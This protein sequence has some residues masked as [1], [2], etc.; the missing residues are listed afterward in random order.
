MIDKDF[1]NFISESLKEDIKDGDH[2]SLSIIH[3][4]S[5]S[6][7]NLLIKDEGI[8]AGIEL[9]IM[10]FKEVDPDLAIKIF[11]KDGE[12]VK[13]GDVAF[14]VK[15]S[16]MSILKSERLVLNCMQHMSS[17]A[18]KTNYLNSLIKN[19][20]TK[21]LDTRK[22]IPLNRKL[23]KW[24]VR[25]GGGNN[26]RMGLYDM[27]MIKDNHIDIAK[28]IEN[29]ISLSQDYLYKKDK[30]LKIIVEAR[31]LN[32]V[33]EIIKI[34]GVDRILLDNFNFENTKKA[35]ELVRGKYKLESS[36]NITVKTIEKYADC[37]VD[38][39]SV[40][41]LTTAINTFDLS[42]KII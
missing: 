1:K 34:G 35:V 41:N 30:K 18:T 11:K 32:E 28:G 4:N 26:H 9:A 23:Q 2:T 12:K 19:K 37:G 31:N 8:I 25:I 16:S 6:N 42:L 14:S 29:A 36:G 24:A 40:G 20:K 7:A 22:T 17:I 39:I 21:L 5:Q 33:K 3:K 10:I 38:Y 13:N 15:G 27:I